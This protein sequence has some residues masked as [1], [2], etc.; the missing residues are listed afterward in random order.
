MES[1]GKTDMS[2]IVYYDFLWQKITWTQIFTY[3]NCMFSASRRCQILKSI[4][5]L[6]KSMEVKGVQNLLIVTSPTQR[7][8]S[9]RQ[10]QAVALEV[11]HLI[12]VTQ[13][14]EVS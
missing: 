11:L 4:D 12:S 9:E 8:W 2:P 1:M 7:L 14:T 3:V 5:P 6:L 13:T 10:K